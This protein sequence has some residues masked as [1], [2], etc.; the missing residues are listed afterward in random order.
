MEYQSAEDVHFGEDIPRADQFFPAWSACTGQFWRAQV[1][2]PSARRVQFK[3]FATPACRKRENHSHFEK[4]SQSFL[5]PWWKIFNYNVEL[6]HFKPFPFIKFQN[7]LQPWWKIFNKAGQNKMLDSRPLFFEIWCG[8]A[9][10]FFIF[11]PN[12]KFKTKGITDW[13]TL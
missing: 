11:Y 6:D 9:D 8:R 13:Q 7:F 2:F 4:N 10:L 12:L 1:A 5:Q 3:L